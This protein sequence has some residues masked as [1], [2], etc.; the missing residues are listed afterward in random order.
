MS[1]YITMKEWGHHKM[2]GRPTEGGWE[3]GATESGKGAEPIDRCADWIISTG[4]T[5]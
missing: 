2:W 1:P 4:W 5:T 3:A